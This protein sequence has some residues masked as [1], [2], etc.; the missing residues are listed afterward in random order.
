MKA[1]VWFASVRVDWWL[2][3]WD[4]IKKRLDKIRF[5]LY[6]YT[7]TNGKFEKLYGR[8]SSFMRLDGGIDQANE[9]MG[10]GIAAAA[11]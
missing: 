3:W 11:K 10:T 4:G 6:I 1:F 8:R 7:S 5:S 2:G 9:A